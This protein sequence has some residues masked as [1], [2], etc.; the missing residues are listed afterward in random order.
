MYSPDSPDSLNYVKFVRIEELEELSSLLKNLDIGDRVVNGRI[1]LFTVDDA[2]HSSLSTQDV[3]VNLIGSL[4]KPF[5]DYDFSSIS[6]HNFVKCETSTAFNIINSNFGMII[7][8]H[9]PGF[10]EN[11][12]KLIRNCVNLD[13][14]QLFSSQLNLSTCPTMWS[15]NYFFYDESQK[16]I[17]YLGVAIEAHLSDG[18]NRSTEEPEPDSPSEEEKENSEREEDL[19]I[20][21]DI[22]EEEDIIQDDLSRSNSSSSSDE[23]QLLDIDMLHGGFWGVN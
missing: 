6:S 17:L 1:Q 11:L 3:L 14:T 13:S 16:V 21:N 20:L 7:E 23:Q 4:N 10:V 2:S 22:E 12:W 15:F 5:S 9:T 8:R 19:A 18:S